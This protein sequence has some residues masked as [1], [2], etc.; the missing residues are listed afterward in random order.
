[1][2]ISKHIEVENNKKINYAAGRVRLEN[3]QRIK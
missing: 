2:K 1:L 3:V